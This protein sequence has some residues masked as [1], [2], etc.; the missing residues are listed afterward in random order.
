VVA[1]IGMHALIYTRRADEVR[2]LLRDVFE[3][4]SVDAGGGWLIF[5][6]PPTELGV[7]PSEDHAFHELHLMCDDIEETVQSLKKKGVRVSRPVTDQGYGLVTTLRLP[8]GVE[9]GLYQPTHPL[10][11]RARRSRT[12]TAAKGRGR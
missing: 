5:A 9:L 2:R 10:A 4:K 3:W 1:I 6:A 11:I 8:G 7:H 12:R